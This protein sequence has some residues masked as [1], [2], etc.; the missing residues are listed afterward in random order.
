MPQV[1]RCKADRCHT[2]VDQSHY[3]C[4]RHRGQEE[5]YIAKQ[6]ERASR[7]RY[8]KYTRNRNNHKIEQ[9][10]F[11][12]SKAWVDMRQAIL[13]EQYYLC[14]YCMAN[15]RVTPN[16][17]T[18][19]HV[20]PIEIAPELRLHK[21][22]L[23][24]TCRACHNIKTKLEQEIYGTGQNNEHKNTAIRLSVNQWAKLIARN[25]DVREGI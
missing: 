18:V 12:R 11:Y 24:V 8:N 5:C 9:Y 21:D 7:S 22:N 10:K 4:D 14:Q 1:R 20:T 3:F 25:Q 19:D 13:N 16:S 15:R 2:L 17:K 23:V 6:N